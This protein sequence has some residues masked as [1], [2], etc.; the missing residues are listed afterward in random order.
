MEAFM[1]F[2]TIPGGVTAAQGFLAAGAAA[3]VKYRG[4]LD[5][6]LLYSEVPASAA[7]VF[8]TNRVKAAPLL[9]T[10]EHI[11]GGRARAVVVNSGNANACTGEQ[12]WR[13]AAAMARETARALDVEEKE[14]LVS[15]TGVIGQPM[16]ME[17]ILPGIAAAARE[18]GRTGGGAAAE[19]ILT[20]DTCPK[21]LAVRLDIGG[22]TVTVGGMAKGSGMIHPNMATMLC[23]ITTDAAV[24]A[25]CLR[26]MLIFATARSFNMISVDRDTSTNDMALILANGR[27]GNP[28]ISGAGEDYRLLRDAV[29]QVCV[30]L[31]REI[32]RDGEG[33]GRLIEVQVVNAPAEKDAR[34]AARAVVAS[35]LV[36]AAVYGLDANWGRILCAAGYSGAAF[37]PAQVDIFLGGVQVAKDGGALPFDEEAARREMETDTVRILIDFKD[38]AAAATAWGCDLTHE[39][40]NIN[41]SYRT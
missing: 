35:N 32:A 13:D 40:V 3:G 22:K 37:D 27:A 25:G 17:R 10:M 1:Q 33:A 28:E 16:P 15:S 8:T 12:G 18:L 29:L 9:L 4:K 5:L 26:E 30:H 20:T 14:V 6:A 38:G 36:K 11:A 21:Q 41:A 39:Y 23:F 19:A 31:A 34:L 24:S 7:G 2:E